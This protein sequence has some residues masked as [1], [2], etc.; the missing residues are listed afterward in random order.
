MIYCKQNLPEVKQV[1][2]IQMQSRTTVRRIKTMPFVDHKNRV[3]RPKSAAV[4]VFL[5]TY[6]RTRKSMAYHFHRR[7]VVLIQ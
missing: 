3:A 7:H 6:R 5:W 2:N 1:E 4:R